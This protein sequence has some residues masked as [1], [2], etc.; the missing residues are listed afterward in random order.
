MMT[1]EDL[2]AVLLMRKEAQKTAEAKSAEGP[3]AEPA[4][5][6]SSSGSKG[7]GAP[8]AVVMAESTAALGRGL[9]ED[10][11]SLGDVFDGEAARL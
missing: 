6:S 5:K 3:A 1:D 2:V 4:T 11:E 10:R 8:A 9:E 7:E